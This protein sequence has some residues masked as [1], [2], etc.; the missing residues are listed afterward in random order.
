M[1]EQIQLQWHECVVNGKSLESCQ[2]MAAFR[3]M[4]AS[5]QPS[6]VEADPSLEYQKN[7]RLQDI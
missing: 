4:E 1:E 7:E 6:A 2:D 3:H 5:R